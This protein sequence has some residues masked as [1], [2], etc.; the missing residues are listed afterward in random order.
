MQ[1]LAPNGAPKVKCC[2]CLHNISL[3]SSAN[4]H[5]EVLMIKMCVSAI[6]CKSTVLSR[7]LELVRLNLGS[8]IG[9]A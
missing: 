9:L 3:K 4:L 7:V 6:M 2:H 5:K 1:F 8:G